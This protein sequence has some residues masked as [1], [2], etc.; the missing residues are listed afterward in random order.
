MEPV[1]C[2][3]STPEGQQSPSPRARTISPPQTANKTA[4]DDSQ[5]KLDAPEAE[6]GKPDDVSQRPVAAPESPTPAPKQLKRKDKKSDAPEAAKPAN[7]EN[8]SG[9]AATAAAAVKEKYPAVPATE[10][11]KAQ[12][13][14]ALGGPRRAPSIF[15]EEQI[16]GR[17]QAWDRIPMPLD[18]RKAKKPAVAD[19]AGPGNGAA[20]PVPPKGGLP[21][22]P[23][24]DLPKLSSPDDCSDGSKTIAPE[25][26]S[27]A[28][29]PCRSP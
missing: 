19:A 4:N 25:S 29:S 7:S 2:R 12:P 16:R 6:N 18:P 10:S 17:Q 21:E 26:G 28:S 27:T 13:K 22:R 24:P 5:Q 14:A 11:G 15:T 3:V 8:Q 1:G 9:P 20:K 23:L